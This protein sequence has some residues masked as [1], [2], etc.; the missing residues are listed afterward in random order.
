MAAVVAA[1]GLAAFP[2]HDAG[3]VLDERLP[4][5]AQQP[6]SMR[7]AGSETSTTA[8]GHLAGALDA[9]ERAVAETFPGLGPSGAG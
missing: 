5:F 3:D 6:P 8:P 2:Q 9:A 1:L 4:G 7:L